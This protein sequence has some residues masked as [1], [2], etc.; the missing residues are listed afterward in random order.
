MMKRFAFVSVGALV[1]LSLSST[2][3]AEAGKAK[4]AAAGKAV[5]WAAEDVKW[6]DV[7]GSPVKMAVLW[8]DPAKGPHGALHKFPAGFEAPCALDGDMVSTASAAVG[9]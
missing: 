9:C 4:A 6:V 7:P 2:G 1:A 5:L 3:Y 8:G